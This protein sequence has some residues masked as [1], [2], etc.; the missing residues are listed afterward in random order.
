MKM[1]GEDHTVICGGQDCVSGY[2]PDLDQLKATVKLPPEALEE[3][4]AKKPKF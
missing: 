4:Q 1:V 3:S 2:Q